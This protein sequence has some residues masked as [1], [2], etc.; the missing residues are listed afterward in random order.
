MSAFATLPRSAVVL[1]ALTRHHWGPDTKR[2]VR[3]TAINDGQT[4][5]VRVIGA[6]AGRAVVLEEATATE[7]NRRGVTFAD[8]TRWD[9]RAVNGCTCKIPAALKGADPRNL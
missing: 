7:V 4:I 6:E 2:P 9:V 5:T 3:L 8:G 1:N